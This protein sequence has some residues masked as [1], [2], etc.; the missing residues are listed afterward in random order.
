MGRGTKEEKGI[1]PALRE[2]LNSDY[3]AFW[4][5]WKYAPDLLPEKFKNFDEFSA[6]YKAI[7]NKGLTE[8]DC[9]KF[10]YI[11]KVQ[12]AIK[13][14]MGKQKNARMIELYNTWYE[15]AKKDSN[16]L[17][18]FIKLQDIFFQGEQ[19]NELEKILRNVNVDD[20]EDDYQ[21]N[22]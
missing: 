8:R 22:F 15:A 3:M 21:M 5:V 6:H 10:L 18:E 20:D 19:E 17:K 16:A 14:L 2:M 1:V 13:W 9:E 11:D 12:R 7:S 4:I